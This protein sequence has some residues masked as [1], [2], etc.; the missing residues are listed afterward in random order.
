MV[1]KAIEFA[2]GRNYEMFSSIILIFLIR[3][4]NRLRKIILETLEQKAW[5]LY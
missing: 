3:L 1:L 2:Y 5:L 4:Q